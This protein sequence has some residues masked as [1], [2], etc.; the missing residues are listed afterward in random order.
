METDGLWGLALPRETA[1]CRDAFWGGSC[2][3]A[4]WTNKPK[5]CPEE[6]RTL[7]TTCYKP[8]APWGFP[9][10][11]SVPQPGPG[12][13]MKEGSAAELLSESVQASVRQQRVFISHPCRGQAQELRKTRFISVSL[14]SAACWQLLCLL[15]APVPAGTCLP[16]HGEGLA[17]ESHSTLFLP[18]THWGPVSFPSGSPRLIPV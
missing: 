3:K 6:S 11:G 18:K 4:T 14:F 5:V 8:A 15:A 16:G 1:T 2:L 13:G 9:S 10:L 7:S 12:W 17:W